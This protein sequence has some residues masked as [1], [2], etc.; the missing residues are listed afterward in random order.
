M[1]VVKVS[2]AS[3]LSGTYSA[4]FQVNHFILDDY[5]N[6]FTRFNAQMIHQ[7][8]FSVHCCSSVLQSSA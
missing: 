6:R 5:Y 7:F 1:T 3:Y 2:R 8:T 4:Y